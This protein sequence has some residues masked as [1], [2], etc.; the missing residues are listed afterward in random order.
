MFRKMRR[1]GQQLTDE[2]CKLVLKEQW[3]GVLSVCG[4]DDYPYGVPMDFYYDEEEQALYFHGAAQGHKHDAIARNDKAC[5]T[6]WD[7]GHEIEG[8]WAKNFHSV[9]LFGRIHPYAGEDKT[10]ILRKMGNKYY[11][12]AAEVEREIEKDGKRCYLLEFKIEQ[13]SG[14]K[15][16]EK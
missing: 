8:D 10:E 16:N 6:V 15:V 13:M 9:I 11:P 7:G 3:R 14:K 12:D 4:D 5:F 1:F 2:Q